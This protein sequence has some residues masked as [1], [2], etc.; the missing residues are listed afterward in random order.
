M[1]RSTLELVLTLQ[2]GPYMGSAKVVSLLSFPSLSALTSARRR[3]TLPIEMVEL[4]DRK[5]FW[6]R[7]VDVARWIESVEQA[8]PKTGT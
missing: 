3:G 6:A 5:G 7:T 4:P 8:S 1:T 2:H